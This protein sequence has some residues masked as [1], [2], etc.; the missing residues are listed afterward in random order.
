[1]YILIKKIKF[2]TFFLCQ[3]YSKIDVLPEGELEMSSIGTKE[4]KQGI[5]F[6]EQTELNKTQYFDSC[7]VFLM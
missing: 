5:L 1:M 2:G 3:K 6:T 7:I 4:T